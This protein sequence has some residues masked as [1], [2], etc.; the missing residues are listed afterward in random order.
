MSLLV[1]ALKYRE[2][3]LKEHIIGSCL[4]LLKKVLLYVNHKKN[5]SNLKIPV[6]KEKIVN[7]NLEAKKI[8]AQDKNK[9]SV[10]IDF[11]DTIDQVSKELSQLSASSR[12]SYENL[13]NIISSNFH[14]IKSALLTYS[15]IK[16]KF[17]YK[18]GK[19]IDNETER[20]LSFDIK[21]NDIFKRMIKDNSYVLYPDNL[22]F[23]NLKE[24]YSKKDYENIDF[25]AFI[26]F[27][28]LG[29][30]VGI[31]IGLKLEEKMNLT[32]EI[33]ASLEKIGLLNGNL[34]Y[35]IIQNNNE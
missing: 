12:L 29:H 5:K 1:K 9:Q 20:K 26:P 34:L 2:K 21:Y 15:P 8:K 10:I 23:Y 31:F 24:I 13:L 25:Q 17:I 6:K 33:V 27:I 28:F 22:L 4:G 16:D 19:N 35:K 18:N 7:T 11:S 30:V 3:Y 14:F 32:K